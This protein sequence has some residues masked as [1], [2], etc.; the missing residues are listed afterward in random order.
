M[1]GCACSLTSPVK[2]PQLDSSEMVRSTLADNRV[3]L[4]PL[5][6]LPIL[7]ALLDQFKKRFV[8]YLVRGI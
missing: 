5:E 4:L 7:E 2:S 3:E 6:S 1:M 8:G